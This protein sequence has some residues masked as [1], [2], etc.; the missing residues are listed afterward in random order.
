MYHL[1]D[2]MK[3]ATNFGKLKLYFLDGTSSSFDRLSCP[4]ICSQHSWRHLAH[5][6]KDEYPWTTSH[7]Q[8]IVHMP[9]LLG[10]PPS[11]SK[12]LL[13][14]LKMTVSTKLHCTSGRNDPTLWHLPMAKSI[15]CYYKSSYRSTVHMLQERAIHSTIF[16][17]LV[18][19]NLFINLARKESKWSHLNKTK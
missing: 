4:S 7:D 5:H 9:Q 16:L 19:C 15:Q 8:I 6:I 18:A 14:W 10:I 17:A 1:L 2:S 11:K 3:H 12:I 13:L